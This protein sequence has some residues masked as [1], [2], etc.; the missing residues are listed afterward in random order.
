MMS[1]NVLIF[2]PNDLDLTGTGY[3]RGVYKQFEESEA[4]Y[5]TYNKALKSHHQAIGYIGKKITDSKSKKALF[6]IDNTGSIGLL[7]DDT[8]SR[9]VIKYEYQAFQNSDLI[10][11]NVQVYGKH[12]NALMEELRK[13]KNET[14]CNG[15]YTFIK[16]GLLYLIWIVDCIIELIA[17]MDMVVSCSHTFTYFGESMQNLKWFVE[18][19]LYEKKLTPKLGNALLAKI[20]DVICGI[21][22]MNCFLHHQH[23][24]L[25]AFQDAVEIIISNLKGLL[26]YLM[27]SPIGLKLN[28]AFNRSLGQFFFYHISLWRLFLHGIQ[29]LFANNFKLIVLPGI[30]GFSFQLAMIAD[31]ISI[32]TF[33]VYC[34]YVYA[35][36]L[37]NLQL[38]G[39]VSLWRLFIGRKYNPLRN[40]VDSCKYSSN[41]LSIGTMGFTVLLFLLPTTTM[42]Y[43]VFSMFRLLILSVTGLLQ[44][45]RYLLNALPIY[46]MCLWIVRSSSIAGT[47]FSTTT[48]NFLL[49]QL[50]CS[51]S[52][53]L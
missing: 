36:R 6:F 37:F 49:L 11:R 39:I 3:L 22:L 38:R 16:M 32:A 17:K 52:P 12:F 50:N 46:V 51:T 30:L 48:F 33:H 29:P 15:K 10:F 28:H 42:Y 25:Y 45:M 53:I 7:K 34:I 1:R 9:T 31:I 47:S 44:G 23:E 35:A 4:Y 5:I 27:G 24:I 14:N 20:V 19:I 18:S 8:N 13:N 41:Q 21:L 43:A 40:R 26:I 2:L